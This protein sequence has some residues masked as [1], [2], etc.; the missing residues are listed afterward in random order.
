MPTPATRW[1]GWTARA[2]LRA[3]AQIL[4]KAEC[5]GETM[6]FASPPESSARALAVLRLLLFASFPCFIPVRTRA[7]ARALFAHA[8]VFF[9][10]LPMISAY[11]SGVIDRFASARHDHE[12]QVPQQ[13]RHLWSPVTGT[14]CKDC[15]HRR[16]Q[17]MCVSSPPRPRGYRRKDCQPITKALR[18]SHN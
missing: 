3:N 2:V 18:I 5:R 10:L 4:E 17:G 6:E 16:N 7:V 9:H 14:P 8:R 1:S 15:A 12:G 11:F 13:W